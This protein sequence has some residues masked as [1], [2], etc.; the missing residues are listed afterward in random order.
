VE[1]EQDRHP[2]DDQRFLEELMLE[3]LDRSMDEVASVIDD[4][5]PDTRGKPPSNLLDALFDELNGLVR[6][7]AKPRRGA[8]PTCTVATSATRIGVP[9]GVAPTATF[10]MSSTSSR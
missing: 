7:G 5:Q 2:G 10:L 9:F 6:I 1:E 4:P 3:V 8:G